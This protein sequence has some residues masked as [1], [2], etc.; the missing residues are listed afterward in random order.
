MADIAE[1]IA[2]LCKGSDAERAAIAR[3]L[4]CQGETAAAALA[5]A[6]AGADAE[7]RW[8]LLAALAQIPGAAA[9]RALAAVLAGDPDEGLRAAAAQI[10]GEHRAGGGALIA[11]LQ[12][13]SVFVAQQAAH[14]L[15]R[16]GPDM[17]PEFI[18]LLREGTPRAR[19]AA[20]RA[21]VTIRTEDAIPALIAALED[22]SPAVQFYAE[23][24][25]DRLGVGTV[26]LWPGSQG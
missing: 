13:E 12:D 3:E 10:L 6:L 22:D 21:L 20:A 19:I 23:E 16:M 7:A 5:E 1:S 15:A 4:T 11:A 17:A 26:L 9:T 24:A 14:A 18:A 8:G 2:R 25:L